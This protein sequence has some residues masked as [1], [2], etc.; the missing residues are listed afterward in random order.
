MKWSIFNYILALITLMPL[1]VK[2]S[3]SQYDKHVKHYQRFWDRL[4]PRYGKVQFAGSMG[5]L[6]VGP[7]W[8]YGKHKQWE[9]DVYLGFVPKYSSSDNKITFTLKQNYIP[10]SLPLNEHFSMNPLT[11][12]LYFNSIL[13]DKYWVHEP[14]K[15]PGGY[16]GFSTRV[17]SNFALGQR[18]TY[19]IP[20]A[21]RKYLKSITF[22]YELGTTDVYVASAVSNHYLNLSDIIHLSL[23]L[24]MQLF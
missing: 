22:F 17:R 11:V 12:S 20:D 10:W 13:S 9:T 1:S 15:Y 8:D 4:I 21:Q 23:G 6:S 24:K 14:N 16:Y 2:A 5:L 18:V 3:D 19:H 7:G